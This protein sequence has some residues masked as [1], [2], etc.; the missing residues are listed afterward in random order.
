MQR[1]Y[2]L[3]YNCNSFY[4]SPQLQSNFQMMKQAPYF[5]HRY[6]DVQ[7]NASLL[8]EPVII[9]RSFFLVLI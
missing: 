4:D 2:P 7:P 6:D 3:P 5:D 1:P 8:N 9:H